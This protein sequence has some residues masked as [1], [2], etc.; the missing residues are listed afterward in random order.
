MCNNKKIKQLFINRNSIFIQVFL[1]TLRLLNIL[2]LPIIN[3]M[4]KIYIILSVLLALSYTTANAQI[5]TDGDVTVTLQPFGSHDTNN[6]ATNGQMFYQITINNSFIGDSVKI[7]DMSGYLVNEAMNS[8]GQNPWNVS[9]PVFNAFGWTSDDQVSGD[10]A[11][12]GGTINKVISGADTVYNINNTYQVYVP[13]P[14]EYSDISG[15]VYIDYNSD[16]VFN[17]SDVALN[18]IGVNVSETLNSPSMTSISFSSSS[19]VTGDYTIHPLKSWMTSTTVSIPSSYQF[20]F[21]ST[22]CSPALY[23]FTTLPQANA[24]FSLQCTSL[25]DVQ[26][27]AGSEGVV[28][29]N[30]PFRLFP[31]VSNTGCN[32]ASGLLKLVLDPEVVYNSSLSSNPANSVAGDTLI[33][34]F[35]N[36][37]NLSSGGYW[38]SFLSG[39]HLTPTAAVNIGDTLC[40]RIFTAVPP[41]DVNATNNDYTICLPVVNS[42][43]PNFKE[44]SPK[45]TGAAGNIPLSTDELTYTIHFQNTGTATA[46]NI[47][48]IDSLDSDITPNSLRILGTSH[49]ATP[50]WLAPGVVKFN[51]FNIY[52][53]DSG[54]NEPESHGFIR[55]SVKLNA[56]LPLGTEIK[57]MA[58]IYFDSNPAI[59]TNTVTNTLANLAGVDEVSTTNGMVTVYP[60]PTT[61]IATFVFQNDA[62]S[63]N[64]SFQLTDIL[65]HVVKSIPEISG[66]QFTVS[67]SGLSDGIYFYKIFTKKEILGIGKLIIE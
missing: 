37:T 44:V 51:F 57:N 23:N 11:F 31:Y 3:V 17:G 50:Q 48:L 62:V 21:P 12:F 16:C 8:T 42:Y 25:V 65:G 32:T 53:P 36:L 26:C 43:D 30:I 15:K 14:C 18:A 39:V 27:Y 35:S 22:A 19:N 28:R 20:I 41:G 10:Y 64:Y 54:S 5:Y 40:F 63:G 67:R 13:D 58:Q 66:T 45:G 59:A 55:F 56:S 46:Y 7:K 2:T 33:W 47:S 49:T 6:C 34:N 60:N 52:L 29:P 38:N 24:D 9:L 1:A 61:D 4:K